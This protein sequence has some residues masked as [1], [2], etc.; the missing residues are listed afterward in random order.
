MR[1]DQIMLVQS[2]WEEVEPMAAKIGEI[3]YR[4]LFEAAP[5]LRSMFTTDEVIQGRVIMGMLARPIEK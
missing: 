3:F 5:E 1:P 4:R 2:T